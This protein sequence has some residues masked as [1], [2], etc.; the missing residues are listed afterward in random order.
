V[1]EST[2]LT[3]RSDAGATP[4]TRRRVTR[5]AALILKDNP[6]RDLAEAAISG[7]STY[8]L[9]HDMPFGEALSSITAGKGYSKE[10]REVLL[11]TADSYLTEI[12]D[13]MTPAGRTLDPLEEMLVTQCVLLHARFIE[14]SRTAAVQPNPKWF[15]TMNEACDRVANQFRRAMQTL[16]DY[17]NPRTTMFVK[18]QANVAGQQVVQ[19]TQNNNPNSISENQESGNE[20]ETVHESKALPVVAGGQEIAGGSGQGNGSEVP[21][22]GVEHRPANGRGKGR[23]RAQQSKARSV[24]PRSRRNAKSGSGAD[25]TT[26]SSTPGV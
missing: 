18:G 4:P 24:Q 25:R 1:S 21:S 13:G 15:A 22:V 26:D 14:I 10:W 6:N 9:H 17:R 11:A 20:L 23:V 5:S 12:F 16:S 19:N 2:A 7:H 3:T 8:V